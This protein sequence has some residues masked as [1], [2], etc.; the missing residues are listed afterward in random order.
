MGISRMRVGKVQ[1]RATDE[2][3]YYASEMAKRIGIRPHTSALSSSNSK[4][5][6]TGNAVY[7]PP[8]E[9][10]SPLFAISTAAVAGG[11]NVTIKGVFRTSV[12][13]TLTVKPPVTLR[14]E[15]RVKRARETTRTHAFFSGVT[16]C[17][18]LRLQIGLDLVF[19]LSAL[20][21]DVENIQRFMSF[22]IDQHHFDT[23]PG[24]REGG[25]KIV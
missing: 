1:P 12:S 24:G 16:H 18:Q 6:W 8:G 21:G 23:A 14:R 5:A 7:L 22:G 15:S 13:S 17:E 11:Q 20:F 4:L 10:Q 3:C 9:T 2:A 25:G 19:E